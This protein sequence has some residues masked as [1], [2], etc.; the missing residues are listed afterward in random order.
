MHIFLRR[1]FGVTRHWS[2]AGNPHLMQRVL[3][4]T[5]R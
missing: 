1:P 4:S 2:H 5:P 3:V